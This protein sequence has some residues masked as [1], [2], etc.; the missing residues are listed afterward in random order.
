MTTPEPLTSQEIID[1]LKQAFQPIRCE[2]T[3]VDYEKFVDFKLFDQAGKVTL[4]VKGT[5]TDS[6]RDENYLRELCDGVIARL[7]IKSFNQL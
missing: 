7:R 1:L 3:L 4:T 6:L 2:A 5:K